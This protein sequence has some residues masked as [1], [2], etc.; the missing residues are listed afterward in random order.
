MKEYKDEYFKYGLRLITD[1]GF[2]FLR[3]FRDEKHEMIDNPAEFV[4]L[5]LDVCDRQKYVILK[6]QTA[7]FI[8]TI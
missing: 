5:A 4:K 7:K 2:T 1:V 8:E 3:T 6:S